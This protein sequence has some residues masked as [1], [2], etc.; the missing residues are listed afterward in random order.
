[1]KDDVRQDATANPTALHPYGGCYGN[2]PDQIDKTINRSNVGTSTIPFIQE[3]SLLNPKNSL[4]QSYRPWIVYPG[5]INLR[6][7]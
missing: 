1:L 7:R 5:S 4:T 6:G 3:C 2:S